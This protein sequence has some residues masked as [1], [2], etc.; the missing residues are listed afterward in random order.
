MSAPEKTEIQ[1][2]DWIQL[3]NDLN[4]ST[5]METNKEKMIRKIKENPFV[6]LGKRL[7]RFQLF[8]NLFLF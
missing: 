2:F 7:D 3:H 6:P 5:V 4:A 8:L 1:E